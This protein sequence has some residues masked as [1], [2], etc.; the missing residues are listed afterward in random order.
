MEPAGKGRLVLN[1]FVWCMYVSLVSPR[2]QRLHPSSHGQ[3]QNTMPAFPPV[4]S[5]QQFEHCPSPQVCRLLPEAWF[6]ASGIKD[7][8][9]WVTAYIT[10]L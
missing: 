6:H 1:L 9:Y 4:G 7:I 2:P 10:V 3:T 5:N 8:V